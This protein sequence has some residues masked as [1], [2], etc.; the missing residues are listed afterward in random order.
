MNALSI[1]VPSSLGKKLWDIILLISALDM[2]QGVLREIFSSLRSVLRVSGCG[3]L[4]GLCLSRINNVRPS[5]ENF[6]SL[7]PGIDAVS[8]VS[9]MSTCLSKVAVD[10]SYAVERL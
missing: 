4:V 7:A 2:S 8:L 1:S 9:A 3:L 5:S 10:V 6:K